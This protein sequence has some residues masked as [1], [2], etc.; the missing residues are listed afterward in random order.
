MAKTYFAILGVA[1]NASAE[2]IRSAYRRLAKEFHPDHFKGDSG[3]FR[4]IQEAYAVLGD[5]R[6]RSRYRQSLEGERPVRPV[7]RSHY[8]SPEPL[9]PEQGPVD[10]GEISPVRSFQSFTPSLDE[11][12][13]W[14]W[15]D[16]PGMNRLKSG[17]VQELTLAVPL[18]REQA[19]RGGVARVM[20]PA[21]VVCPSCR[22]AGGTLF[23]AC[24]R[25]AGQGYL[26]G[27]VPVS[28]SF[29]AGLRAD[30][31]VVVPPDRLGLGYLHLTVLF[32]P[33]DAD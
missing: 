19:R 30:H 28:I 3:P 5:D 29:P 16:L 27:E 26:S 11:M 23:Y 20:V 31:A 24:G 8:G 14:L 6:S 13:E 17:R 25:C 12:F 33:T 32:R 22:G 1:S 18:T 21:R 10:M 9:I 4:Q 15:G 7:T 2:E